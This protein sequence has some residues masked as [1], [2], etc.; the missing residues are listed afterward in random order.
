MK[1]NLLNLL[2]TLTFF[3]LLAALTVLP[4]TIMAQSPPTFPRVAGYVGI[5]HPIVTFNK[6][7]SHVNFQ[8]SYVGGLPTGINIWKSEK[9]GFSMEI[10]PFIRSEN[11]TAKMS[12]L[13][14]HPGILIGLGKGYTLVGRAAFETSG[15]FGVTPVFNKV[16]KKNKHSNYFVAVPIPVRFGNDLPSS[17]T[18][19]FQFGIGF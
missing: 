14:F 17:V 7:G 9:I 15:R 5:I 13:L 10:V 11:N 1:K 16:V 8:H 12:N 19:G 4:K 2:K 3:I 6:E 18:L